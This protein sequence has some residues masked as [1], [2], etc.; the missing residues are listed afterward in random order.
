M[1][2]AASAG[3]FEGNGMAEIGIIASRDSRVGSEGIASSKA[4]CTE[5]RC[6]GT[7]EAT[8]RSFDRRIESATKPRE[9]VLYGV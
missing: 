6:P 7:P 8:S 4:C 2:H 1:L 3:T 5:Y 9:P